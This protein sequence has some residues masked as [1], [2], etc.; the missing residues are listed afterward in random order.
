MCACQIILA[1]DR[2]DAQT[3]YAWGIVQY[4]KNGSDDKSPIELAMEVS[5]KLLKQSATAL[6][7]SELITLLMYVII[8]Q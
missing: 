4:F 6:Q 2:I 8:S 3:A 5:S 7:V 1:G